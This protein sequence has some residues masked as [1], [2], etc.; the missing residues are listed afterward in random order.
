MRTCRVT[1]TTNQRPTLQRCSRIVHP[2]G[3]RR[4]NNRTRH[5][6]PP[7]PEPAL[8]AATLTDYLTDLQNSLRA[9]VHEV[10]RLDE[11]GAFGTQDRWERST[12]T[13]TRAGEK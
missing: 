3:H 2:H 7:H 6:P 11:V 4:H 10:G 8:D 9:V 12:S 1:T 13:P 5:R